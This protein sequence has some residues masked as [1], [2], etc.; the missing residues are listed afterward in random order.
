MEQKEKKEMAISQGSTP[1]AVVEYAI[2]KGASVDELEKLLTLQER[3]DANQARKSYNKA[4]ADFKANPPKI[5]KDRTVKY[6]NTQY[7]HA[8][9]YNITEKV[10]AE[11]TKHALSASWATKQNGAVCVTCK[12]THVQGHSEETTLQAPADTSGSKNSIQAIG[13]TITYL[14]RYTL[15]ALTGLAT[16][17]DD[18]GQAAATEYIDEKQLNE[19]TDWML[20]TKSN[21]KDF[22]K[23][24]GIE[25]VEKLPKSKFNQAIAVFKAKKKSLATPTAGNPK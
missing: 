16:H 7:N 8:S 18:D 1:A 2:K 9:L 10:N 17:E 14:Q 21:S 13:S 23:H 11:L 12:I 19:I 20:D 25:S 24:F 3:Y 15:L 5:E 22:C 4:M 6:G